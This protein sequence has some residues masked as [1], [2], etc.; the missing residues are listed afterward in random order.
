MTINFL[1]VINQKK[2]HFTHNNTV[3]YCAVIKG[4]Y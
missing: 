4:S 3:F 1:V 2:L